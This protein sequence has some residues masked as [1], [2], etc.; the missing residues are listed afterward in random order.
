MQKRLIVPEVIL[1]HDLSQDRVSGWL[2]SA[3]RWGVAGA[4]PLNRCRPLAWNQPCTKNEES[5]TKETSKQHLSSC[6]CMWVFTNSCLTDTQR[7]PK[8]RERWQENY[9]VAMIIHILCMSRKKK[10]TFRSLLHH[11]SC[12]V[13]RSDKQLLDRK[14]WA[15]QC[16][17]CTA[18]RLS[19][20]HEHLVHA[21][22][23][24]L[25]EVMCLAEFV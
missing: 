1:L 20:D 7:R 23:G 3:E 19:L 25:L 18:S 8:G 2:T 13:K 11:L 21:L 12:W 10:A 17:H 9:F 5:A 6:L 24:A 4:A 14:A 15:K 22:F 16:S